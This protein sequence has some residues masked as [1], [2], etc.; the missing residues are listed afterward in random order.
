MKMEP[1][2][3]E[4]YFDRY[5]F[6]APFLLCCSDCETVTVEDLLKGEQGSEE[7]FKNLRLGYTES[8]GSPSLREQ[9]SHLYRN[10]LPEQILIHNGAEEAIFLFMN[11]VI[12]PG[13]HIILHWPCY[14]SLFEVARSIGCEV[15]LWNGK[16]ENQWDLDLDFLKN[17]IRKNTRA[18]II[19][20]PHNPTGYVM[21]AE[22]WNEVNRLAEKHGL[23]VFSDE[24]YSG[25][26]YTLE[27]KREAFCDINENAISLNVLSKSYG[28]AGLRI[29]WVATHNKAIQARMAEMKDYTTICSSGPSEFLAELALR[30]GANL[31]FQNRQII[32]D[33][34]E[35]WD[36]FFSRYEELFSW[37]KPLAGPIGF[38]E[39][40]KQTAQEFCS[41]LVEKQGVLLLPGNLYGEQFDKNF[42]IGFGRKNMPEALARLEAYLKE[43]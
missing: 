1:F 17:N 8:Q 38:P 34:L 13:D 40:R 24:V 26:E 30:Q 41:D 28:L 10:I 22:K 9:I 29:G 21:S 36:A 5:E 6:K 12:N 33:N 39:L 23:I 27:S 14:Q 42:R 2:R 16:P 31:Q 11:A 25:L 18:I 4:R 37:Q 32:Q 3:L 7:R 15:S 20:C 19:N 35:L 43:N